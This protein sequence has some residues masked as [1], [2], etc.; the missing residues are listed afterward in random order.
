MY[1]HIEKHIAVPQK[2]GRPNI[3]PFDEMEV[4]DSFVVH[5]DIAKQATMAAYRYAF[6]K[7]KRG[8]HRAFVT[9]KIDD[10]NTR[11]WRSE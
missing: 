4:G 5:A 9:R 10:N 11:I 7:R 8:E 2:V 3:Y 6:N 1:F